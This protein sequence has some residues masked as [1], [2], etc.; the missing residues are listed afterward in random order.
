MAWSGEGL[1]AQVTQQ[2]GARV[3]HGAV[4]GLTPLGGGNW[5]GPGRSMASER[6]LKGPSN[7]QKASFQSLVRGAAFQ[8]RVQDLGFRV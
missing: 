1:P 7:S 3:V 4:P 8:F 2:H 6:P 5:T